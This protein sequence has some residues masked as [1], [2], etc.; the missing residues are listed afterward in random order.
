MSKLARK[1]YKKDDKNFLKKIKEKE[2]VLK[3][4]QRLLLTSLTCKMDLFGF[5]LTIVISRI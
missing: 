5:G 3:A 4:S 1:I 2:A